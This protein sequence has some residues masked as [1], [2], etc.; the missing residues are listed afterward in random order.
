MKFIS[1]F[2][3]GGQKPRIC[4]VGG[5]ILFLYG[6]LVFNLY[7]IQ[8]KKADYYT[9]RAE[10]QFSFSKTLK[11]DRGTIYFTDK[12]GSKIPAVIGKSYPVIFAV[13]KEIE[14]PQE[15]SA[16]LHELLGLDGASLLSRF[17]NPYDLYER[18]VPKAGD[19]AIKKIKDSELKGIYIAEENYRYYP[20]GSLGAHILGFVGF[21]DDGKEIG[22]YG[23]EKFYESLLAGTY[24]SLR[25]DQIEKS[26]PGTDVYLTIDRNIQ[27]RAEE[28]LSSLVQDR[29]AIGGTIIVQEPVSGKIL[30][31]ASYPTFD[32]NNYANFNYS[33][34]LNQAQSAIYEP[35]S[36]F[37]VLT[38]AAALDAGRV[39]PDTK[40]YDAG[41]LQLN[42]KTIK[43]WD[44]KAHGSVTMTEVI[45]ESINTGA[46]F[47]ERQLGHDNFYK[48]L[49]RFGFGE[50]SG[51][52]LPGEIKGSLRTLIK[53]AQDINF[54][55]VSF[56]QGVSVTPIGLINAVASIA[57]GGFLMR[58]YV[59]NDVSPKIIRRVISKEAG[60]LTTQMM[61]SAVSKAKVAAI[62]QYAV[63][64]KTGTAQVPD[65]KK[66]GYTNEVINTY[67]GYVPAF[68][69]K[70][71]ILIKLDK[72]VGAPLAG[73]T[74]VPAFQ[75]LAQFIINYYNIPPDQK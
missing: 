30:T 23:I 70:F 74:V 31:M 63:A 35:G 42:G 43:N 58:P 21:G 25:G 4:L 37:K 49:L 20:F 61:V 29:Q 9:E 26:T 24:G 17:K 27:S 38:M 11:P 71:I 68:D 56:G 67:V 39:K 15:I 44:L 59:T 50:L 64:G 2:A 62:P 48:Y 47:A 19:T 51:I 54:A 69:P 12:N 57:N 72:P 13:P 14:D 55:T 65:F 5:L 75:E 40:F 52:N 73:T 66:G 28:I 10:A 18:L 41:E 60:L 16:T 34:F 53:P 32:P 22:R 45:E 33:T 3:S 8:I 6:I 46:A 1:F 7:N 36:V